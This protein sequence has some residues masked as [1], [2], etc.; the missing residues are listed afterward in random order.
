MIYLNMELINTIVMQE[1]ELWE[2][3]RLILATDT[4]KD[5][6]IVL[7]LGIVNLT[8]ELYRWDCCQ[9]TN[10]IFLM[11]GINPNL[12]CKACE[13]QTRLGINK[14]VIKLVSFIQE[15]YK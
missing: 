15:C 12:W 9:L 8:D 5:L 10:Q 13:I 14:F 7:L 3:I 1:I 11:Y 2:N 6:Y 4:I